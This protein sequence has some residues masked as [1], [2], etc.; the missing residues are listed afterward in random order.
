MLSPT[1]EKL[2]KHVVYIFFLSFFALS[3]KKFGTP[4]FPYLLTATL[5]LFLNYVIRF[6]L[7]ELFPG[8]L[9]VL[10]FLI[11]PH[12]VKPEGNGG[13]SKVL[14][15]KEYKDNYKV[16]VLEGWKYVRLKD[17]AEPGDLVNSKGEVVKRPLFS[18]NRFRFHLY[19]RIEESLDYPIS[20]LAG[21]VTLG[22]RY[23][24]PASVKGYSALSG[25]YHFLAISGLHVGIV[26]GALAL[27]FKLLRMRKPLTLAS[28]CILPLMPLTGLPPSALRSYLFMFLL[29]VGL[30]NY[31]KITPL[32][33][34]GVVMLFTVLTGKFNLSA[35][36]SFSAVAGILLAVEGEGG[37]FIKSVK[38][39][40]APMFSTLPIVLTTFG[41][42]NPLSWLTTLL[43]GF[44]FTPFLIG[45]FLMEIT[46]EKIPVVNAITEF[47]GYQFILSAHYLFSLT[48]WS[49]THYEA[50]LWL[51]GVTM[52]L[53][54]FLSLFSKPVYAF[55]PP[56]LLVLYSL[57]FPTVISGVRV[58]FPGWKLNS[59]YFVS[60]EG[61]KYR[62]SV[63]EASYVF[64]ATKKLLFRNTLFDNR[65]KFLGQK[66]E[67]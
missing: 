62:N 48:K 10:P 51:S 29:A 46:L 13:L 45:T 23:E 6:K 28:I 41:T 1:G 67:R 19:Q 27:L 16:A 18:L 12:F 20:A 22:F 42:F 24:L 40:F 49:L 60:T 47:L 37:K 61:Q 36:L 11:V 55:I 52:L 66:R 39:S 64:P 35:T 9:V 2:Q 57:I 3:F 58:E 14:W 59:F 15:V 32:Y 5:I 34:L 56:F 21:A 38:A 53:M 4:Y 50:P 44:L 33:L 17:N 43:A 25:I 54:L 31:R 30:E 65:L 26:V 7:M 8:V 63:L